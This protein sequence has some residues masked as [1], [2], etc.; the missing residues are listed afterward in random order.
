MT[1]DQIIAALE[2]PSVKKAMGTLV[3]VYRLS[4]IEWTGIHPA[5]ITGITRCGDHILIDWIGADGGAPIR[6]P[7]TALRY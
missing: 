4:V 5:N 3:D 1:N 7:I 2:L 6:M